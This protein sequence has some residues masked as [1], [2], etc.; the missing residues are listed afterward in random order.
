MRIQG[1]ALITY[2]GLPVGSGGAHRLRTDPLSVWN[3]LLDFFSTCTDRSEP[4]LVE[5]AVRSDLVLNHAVKKLGEPSRTRQVGEHREILRPL[6]IEQVPSWLEGPC[7][8]AGDAG[9][10]VS[11]WG[12]F[13]FTDLQSH[14]PLPGQ[15]PSIY[16]HQ[17]VERGG[18]LLGQS[19]LYARLSRRSTVSV[20][21][22]FPFEAPSAEFRSYLD[23]LQQHLPFRFSNHHWK[24]WRPRARG[25]GFVGRKFEPRTA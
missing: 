17:K 24:H 14:D 20:F 12:Q 19:V 4:E 25:T 7:R 2:D 22:C 23:R 6:P 1:D 13:R 3:Q 8:L 11:A 15:D 10:W 9:P 5:L 18:Y 21:L 16:G